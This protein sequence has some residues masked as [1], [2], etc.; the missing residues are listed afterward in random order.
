VWYRQDPASAFLTLTLTLTCSIDIDFKVS[1]PIA[2]KERLHVSRHPASTLLLDPPVLAPTV[3]L[4]G[5][6]ARAEIATVS[7]LLAMVER[8]PW[9]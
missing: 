2:A 3:L 9:H 7:A 4:H 8:Q 1:P 5:S 6:L